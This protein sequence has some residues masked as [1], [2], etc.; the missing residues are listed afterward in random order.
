MESVGAVPALLRW[1]HPEVR[2]AVEGQELR[3]EWRLSLEAVFYLWL[4]SLVMSGENL[5]GKF[6]TII[7]SLVSPVCARVQPGGCSF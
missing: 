7:N 5:G 3:R 6:A 4:S 2:G 1:G